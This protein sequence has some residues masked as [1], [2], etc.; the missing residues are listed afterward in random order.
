MRRTAVTGAILL[1]S[2]K[3]L[4]GCNLKS[5]KCTASVNVN[6]SDPNLKG[7]CTWEFTGGRAA[8]QISL[9]KTFGDT[10]GNLLYAA[11]DKIGLA[12]VTAFNPAA[13]DPR[14]LKMDTAG[15]TAS[16]DAGSGVFTV[17]LYQG[18]NLLSAQSFSWQRSGTSL[19]PSNPAAMQAWIQQ[20]PQA[21]GFAYGGTVP[22]NAGNT[23]SAAIYT[24]HTYN[25]S[26]A[27]VTTDSFARPRDSGPR[28]T[29][30]EQ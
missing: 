6:K 28:T 18:S 17:R 22:F 20:Y 21:D 3:L 14:L 2:A 23:Q 11:V 8:T 7:E 25:G 4:T 12:R 19:L 24:T 13:F 30:Q 27:Y 1:A 15:S 9:R 26:V 10:I 5:A 16:V 29:Y